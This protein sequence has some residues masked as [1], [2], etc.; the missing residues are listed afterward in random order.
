MYA[1]VKLEVS[2]RNRG[3]GNTFEASVGGDKVPKEF[4]NAIERGVMDKLNS[5]ILAAYS[6]VDISVKLIG[7]SFHEVDSSP[8]AF[9][10]AGSIAV[11]DAVKKAGPRLLEPMMKVDIETPD[12]YV[13]PVNGDLTGRQGIIERVETRGD[14][15]VNIIALVPLRQLFGYATHLRSNSQGR[16]S[17]VAEFHSYQPV[18]VNLAKKIIPFYE[19]IMKEIKSM[20]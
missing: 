19:E 1:E 12:I 4:H 18:P 14:G 9:E 11:E 17:A 7:G 5:G 8:I 2:P 3:S 20:A 15:T 13:G 10:I 6:M 16:A